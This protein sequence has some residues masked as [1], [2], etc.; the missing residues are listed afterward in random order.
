MSRKSCEKEKKKKKIKMTIAK[1]FALNANAIIMITKISENR[2]LNIF[3]KCH[4]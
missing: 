3:E 1:L 2:L 4:L